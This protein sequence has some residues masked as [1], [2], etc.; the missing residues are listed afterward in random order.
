MTNS[1]RPGA[2]SCSAP[3]TRFPFVSLVLGYMNK[4]K[5]LCLQTTEM[6]LGWAALLILMAF[7]FGA[8][9]VLCLAL[10]WL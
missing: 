2:V 1:P 8:L 7:C 3:R 6:I 10:F 9:P 4:A 5:R